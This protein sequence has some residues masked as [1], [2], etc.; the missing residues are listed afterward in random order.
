MFFL[1]EIV[2]DLFK[3]PILFHIEV[4]VIQWYLQTEANTL[5]PTFRCIMTLGP[6]LKLS[7]Q[8]A[9]RFISF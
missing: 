2:F 3:Q 8:K 1:V 4:F 7:L 9:T 5:I 6:R